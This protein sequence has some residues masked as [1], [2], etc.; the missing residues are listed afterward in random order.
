MSEWIIAKCSLINDGIVAQRGTSTAWKLVTEL[1]EGLGGTTR[2][3]APAKKER[4][5]RKVGEKSIE[6]H[7]GLAGLAGR[8]S[9]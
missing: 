6:K 9:G 3:T 7:V 8:P 2:R 4:N 1:R 5:Y